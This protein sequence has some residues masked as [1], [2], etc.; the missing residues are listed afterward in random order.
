MLTTWHLNEKSR[1]FC[2]G[3]LVPR[4]SLLPLLL[5]GV[6][7][8]ETLGTSLLYRLFATDFI[9]AMLDDH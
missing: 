6:G 5:Q 7:R 3:N 8:I 1:E 9:A 4:V 2:I